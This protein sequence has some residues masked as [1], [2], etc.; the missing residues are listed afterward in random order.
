[1]V[2]IIADAYRMRVTKEHWNDLL[3]VLSGIIGSRVTEIHTRDFY[4]GNGKYRRLSGPTRASII[5]QIFNWLADRRHHI[6]YS[7]VDK[8][9]FLETAEQDGFSGDLQTYWTFMATHI[10]LSLQKNFQRERNNKG[11]M[12]LIFDNEEREERRFIDIL[13]NPPDW[14]D[15]YYNLSPRHTKIDQVI[16]VPHF[17]DSKDVGLIQV[18][19]FVCFFLRR[20]LEIHEAGLPPTYADEVE[21]IDGWVESA[22]SR[23]IPKSK[24]YSQRGQCEAMRYFCNYAPSCLL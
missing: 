20:F 13:N 16:D 11:N 18:A 10:C 19:D 9:R 17:V 4:A 12:V 5:T 2:G 23:S 8:R 7:A 1:M 24:I 14:T 21:R 6:V 22:M 15:S 3:D